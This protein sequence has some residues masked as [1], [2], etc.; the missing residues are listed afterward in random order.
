MLSGSGEARRCGVLGSPIAHSLSPAIHRAAYRHLGLSW[1]YSRHEVDES[2]LAAFLAA[3]DSRWRGLSLTMPLKRTALALSDDASDIA[4]TV[5]AANTLIRAEDGVMFADNTDVT[6]V[7]ATLTEHGVEVS[8]HVCLW[9]GGATA[10]SVL[11][12]LAFLDS[13]PAHVHVRSAARAQAALAVTAALGC[14]AEPAPWQVQA[15][16]HTAG[17]VVSTAP[18]GALDEQASELSA[19]STAGRVL[20]DVV[21]DPWPTAAAA[22]WKAAGG[23]VISGLDLLVH[24]AVGQVKLMTGLDV[25]A[26]V[27]R[28]AA[29]QAAAEKAAAER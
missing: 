22:R 21:Y 27:L 12:G 28:S 2:G 11:A 17:L 10:T 6:G 8:S 20:F 18:A 19:E 9:G 1:E 16:C 24:Q 25:P 7:V 26:D 29:E 23:A 4:R 5:G 3:L 13:G 14:P 15:A